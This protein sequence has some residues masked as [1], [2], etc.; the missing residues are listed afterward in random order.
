MFPTLQLRS[1]LAVAFCT[2]ISALPAAAQTSGANKWTWM[3]GSRTVSAQ[4]GVWPGVY[5]IKGM[6]A[7]A[8][9]PPTRVGEVTWTG[10]DGRFWLFGGFN[11]TT[12]MNY[13][14]DL[15]E[16]DPST[17][18]WTWVAG[19]STIGS[20]C[21]V[22]SSE[23]NCGQPGIYG[24][25]GTPAQTNSPG[26]RRNAQSWTDASGDLWLYGGLGFDTAGNL[27]ALDDLW[28]FAISSNAW[29]WVA[30][31]STVPLNFTCAGCISG[32]PPVPGTQGAASPLNT[33]GS[34]W[35]GTTWTDHNGNFWLFS[36]WG[37]APAGY[38]AVA[39]ELWE[40]SPVAR[41]WTWMGGSP[42]FGIDGGV[43]GIYGTLGTPSP[44][45]FPGTR[46]Q[47]AV[48]ID[49]NGKL[50]LFGGQ[51]YDSTRSNEGILN[52]VWEYDPEINE[53]AWMGGSSTFN[54]SDIPKK[55]CNEPGVYGTLGQPS[56]GNIPGSRYAASNWR[57]NSGNF[58]LFGGDG[59]DSN[60]NFNYLNDLW[61]FNPATNEWAWM[62]GSS[63]ISVGPVKGIYG[64]MGVPSSANV[65]GT[66]NLAASWTD[67]NGYLWLW[68]GTGIDSAGVYGYENDLWRYQPP[69]A[70]AFGL[71]GTAVTVASGATTGNTSIITITS[72]NGFTGNVALSA[73]VTSSP[74][75]A[76]DPPTLS[77][78]A[79][80][81]VSITSGGV[82]MAT[83]AISTTAPSSSALH[84]P[85]RPTGRWL[86]EGGGAILGCLLIFGSSAK[87]RRWQTLVAML[88]L[89]VFAGGALGCGGGGSGAGQ[90]NPG[91]RPGS[92]TITVTGSSG[93][94][95][96]TTTV[97][98]TV[99]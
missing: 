1:L 38:A 17:N 5:G 18:E 6:P 29:T 26:A 88:A 59:F 28:E 20:N 10:G 40:F 9:I 45:N 83:L 16:F 67:K 89:V 21:P 39:N 54:C 14:N 78:G 27:V 79:T 31:H 85:N 50:W 55:Y 94:L 41:E 91:T 82:G 34:L 98:L 44:G 46:W 11:F 33:P 90:S 69:S 92:Y 68:G 76:V 74:V 35:L 87:R 72:S 3:G 58:W 42:N 73:S 99:Q 56:A 65:P 30:G 75:G 32:V 51:G 96:Q 97:A 57:D 84:Y 60:S 62:S 64:T 86:P 12:G 4:F 19:D 70:V 93:S 81:T 66:R 80:S 36:G 2:A 8:N 43:A 53:W 25:L 37:Y 23:A 47:D 52:D 7:P 71:S 24:T 15:W 95:T 13:F 77:F 49:K 63:N 61:E 48:W 22:I